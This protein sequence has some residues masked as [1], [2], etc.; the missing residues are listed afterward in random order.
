[1]DCTCVLLRTERQRKRTKEEKEKEK[2]KGHNESVYSTSTLGKALRT[3]VME[4]T[5]LLILSE[6]P[7]VLRCVMIF[8]TNFFLFA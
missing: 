5:R 7:R 4:E 6:D 8:G 2:E 3:Y 1:M